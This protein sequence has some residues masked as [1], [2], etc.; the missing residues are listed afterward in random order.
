VAL[1]AAAVL[2]GAALVSAVYGGVAAGVAVLGLLVT[3]LL[4]VVLRTHRSQ[5]ALISQVRRLTADGTD[6]LERAGRDLVAAVDAGAREADKRHRA[7]LAAIDRQ[8][9]KVVRLQRQQ[10]R[11]FEALLQ[12]HRSTAA[13][14]PLPASGHWALNAT[15]L[16]DVLHLIGEGRPKVVLELGSGT[17]TVWIAYAL[18]RS[19]GRLVSVDHLPE[20]AERT[21]SWLSAHGLTGV[22]EVREA[23]LRPVT[24]GDETFRWY[25]PAAFTDLTDVDLLLV[26]GPPGA[27]GPQ[28]RYPALGVLAERLSTTATVVLDD[29]ERPDE[30]QTV[31]RWMD[32]VD[33]LTRQRAMLGSHAVLSY[34]RPL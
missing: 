15:N 16:L 30:E 29:A 20:Y 7:A 17:S 9:T 12:L 5:L 27:T 11:E 1:C 18:E 24:L 33:G 34:A 32:S 25:D 4:G 6:R 22:A 23:P 2:N 26:D 21:R 10:H 8:H 14:A 13:R 28:A 31:R 19:G 3:V